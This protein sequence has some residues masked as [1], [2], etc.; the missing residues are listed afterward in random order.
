MSQAIEIC[1]FGIKCKFFQS[2]IQSEVKRCP[3]VHLNICMFHAFNNCVFDKCTRSHD[4]KML[5][6]VKGTKNGRENGEL[7]IGYKNNIYFTKIGIFH[8]NQYNCHLSSGSEVNYDKNRTNRSWRKTEENNQSL[9]DT[10]VD[11]ENSSPNE[12]SDESHD[13]SSKTPKTPFSSPGLSPG[14]SPIN[15]NTAPLIPVSSFSLS[16]NDLDETEIINP[17]I[18]IGADG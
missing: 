1:A 16:E 6:S 7:I 12:S 13:E 14:L 10:S 15:S 11:S 18:I 5:K 3:R 4:F 2:D 17:S 9:L 8:K